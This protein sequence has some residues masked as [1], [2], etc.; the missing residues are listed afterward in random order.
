M[1]ALTYDLKGADDV[2]MVQQADNI[3]AALSFRLEVAGG[4]GP[5]ALVPHEGALAQQLDSV[6]VHVLAVQHQLH[7]AKGPLP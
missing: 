3:H 2:G 1:G 5:H 4:A 7:L 6:Q